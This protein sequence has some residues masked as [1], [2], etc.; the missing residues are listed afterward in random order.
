MRA[1]ILAAGRGERLRPLTDECPKPLLKAGGRPLI[2]YHL[3]ALASAG[4][5]DVVINTSWRADRLHT[6]IGD[7]RRF[8]LRVRYSYEGPQPLDTGG[9]IAR[10]LPLLGDD[11]FIVVNG[12]IYTDFPLATLT[13]PRD[14]RQAHLVLVPNPPHNAAGDFAIEGDSL[15]NRPDGR[16][17]FSGIAVYAPA[18]FAG[19]GAGRFPLAPLLRKAADRGRVSGEA[20]HGEW[21]DIGTA[22][23]LAELDRWMRNG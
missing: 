7:G 6:R 15:D 4:V 20:F 21:R 22:E 12:D 16:L 13:P 19:A 10:A 8:G 1:M 11:A 17:T 5:E 23:R 18:F 3:R 2:E 14:D 9:G